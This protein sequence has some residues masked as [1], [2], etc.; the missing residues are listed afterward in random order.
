MQLSNLE[1]L[2]WMST[3]KVS[4]ISGEVLIIL[5]DLYDLFHYAYAG[6]LQI[7]NRASRNEGKPVGRDFRS[8]RVSDEGF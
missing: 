5:I 7:P 6:Q 3:S 1:K 2:A 4:V 8:S